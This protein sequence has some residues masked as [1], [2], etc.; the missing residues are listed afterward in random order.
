MILKNNYLEQNALSSQI[1]MIKLI[2]FQYFYSIILKNLQ[3]N[4]NYYI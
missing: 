2:Q 4:N 1:E 3:T